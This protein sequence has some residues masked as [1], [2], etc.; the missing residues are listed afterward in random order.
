MSDNFDNSPNS[1]A[2]MDMLSI[3]KE[4]IAKELLED[5]KENNTG[6]NGNP[7]GH[8]LIETEN[9]VN[10]AIGH[11]PLSEMLSGSNATPIGHGLVETDIARKHR[12]GDICIPMD[13]GNDAR[14]VYVFDKWYRI[15]QD[16]E[17]IKV[18]TSIEIDDIESL[19]PLLDQYYPVEDEDD[20]DGKEFM[21]IPLSKILGF[22]HKDE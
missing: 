6:S 1:K 12:W 3:T 2:L 17:Y 9:P 16:E 5:K 10:V 21:K 20:V 15:H 11:G 18:P 8:G 7:L 4:A 19:K 14:H 22:K 13:E